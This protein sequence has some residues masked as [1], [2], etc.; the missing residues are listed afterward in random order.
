MPYIGN[1]LATQFQ[2][3]ATQTITGDG[4]TSYTLD[5]AVAN[6]KE[7]LV[8]INN[9]KQEEGSGKSY[10]ASGTTITFSEAVA[11]GDSCYLVYMGSAQQT[12]VPPDGSVG[13]T[14]LAVS[15][16]S[17]GQFLSTNGSGTLSFASGVSAADDLTAGDAAVNLTTTS[18]NITIDAQGSDT[19]IIFKG[20]DDTTDTTFLTLDGSAGGQ[21][22]FV[23][24][25]LST[26]SISFSGDTDT[27]IYH[28]AANQVA[29]AVG[30]NQE[31]KVGSGFFEY[32]G[33]DNSYSNPIDQ[34]CGDE[35][36]TPSSSS[37]GATE[38]LTATRSLPYQKLI[39][40]AIMVYAN[41]NS[42]ITW[43]FSTLV[44]STFY[45]SGTQ[46]TSTVD[47]QS[48][49]GGFFDA[50]PSISTTGGY[51]ARK[52]TVTINTASNSNPAA[53]RVLIRY[54]IGGPT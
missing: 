26:P 52:V 29:I 10:E 45:S 22:Q 39:P 11:S 41:G 42:A 53:W 15:D 34:G 21:A 38:T 13:I 46:V 27:G 32:G 8:Y 47:G 43:H 24:G 48:G 6:G 35:I 1:N 7:L 16:G 14:Q 25:S 51:D 50:T 44:Y 3:F 2:A 49:A 40:C 19:D 31:F 9:V 20:T 17:N 18:G 33:G 4:S 12:V 36:L 5:R 30:G 54:G 37:S 28:S 23:S